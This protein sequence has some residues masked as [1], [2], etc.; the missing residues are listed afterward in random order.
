MDRALDHETAVREAEGR[1]RQHVAALEAELEEARRKRDAVIRA[2]HKA[3]LTMREIAQA[4][5]LSHQR[6]NQIIHER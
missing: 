5:G 3:G 6:V 4:A 2:A 1:Y